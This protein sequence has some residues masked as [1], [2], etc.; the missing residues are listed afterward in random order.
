VADAI[1]LIPHMPDDLM[2]DYMFHTDAGIA[3]QVTE[4]EKQKLTDRGIAFVEL[5]ESANHYAATVSGLTSEEAVAAI[6]GKQSTAL[7][8]LGPDERSTFGVA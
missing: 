4:A 5:F 2:L 6:G 8:S 1:V 3:V 7:A